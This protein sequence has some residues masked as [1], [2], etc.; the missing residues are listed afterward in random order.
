M[1]TKKRIVLSVLTILFFLCVSILH[2]SAYVQLPDRQIQKS[3]LTRKE[4]PSNYPKDTRERYIASIALKKGI[5]FEEAEKLE[6]E[7]IPT[8]R[9]PPDEVVSYK[10][11]DK[12]AG[13]VNDK[14]RR[15][16]NISAEVKY[17]KKFGSGEFIR[18]ENIGEPY[19]YMPKVSFGSF[20]SGGFNIENNGT[21]GRISTTGSVTYHIP[22]TIGISI[23]TGDVAEINGNVIVGLNITTKAKTF[24]IDIKRHDF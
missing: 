3:P 22:F 6:N 2:S 7:D 11:I 12:T 18:I 17:V 13:Y 10:T 14:K 24:V 15:S 21:Y 5:T 8:F 23:K 19:V 1:N 20:S 9:I 16:V 4:D